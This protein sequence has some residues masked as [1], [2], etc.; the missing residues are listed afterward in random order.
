MQTQDK[1]FN[2]KSKVQ[3]IDVVKYFDI[4][5][6]LLTIF[7][8]LSVAFLG[9]KFVSRDEFKEANDVLSGRIGKIEEVLIRMEANYETDKRHDMLLADHESRIRTIEKARSN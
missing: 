4:G 9:T 5:L 8:L 2:Y 3:D 1:N 7:A 6:K